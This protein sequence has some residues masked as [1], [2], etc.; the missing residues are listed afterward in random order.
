MTRTLRSPLALAALVVASALTVTAPARLAA[1]SAEA[2]IRK[3]GGGPLIEKPSLRAPADL[4]Y[5][6]VWDVN[7]GP[8]KPDGLVDGFRRPASFLLQADDNGIPRKNVHLAIIVYGTAAR[9]LLNNATYKAETGADNASI[10]LLQALHQS[11]VRVIVCGEALINRRIA[12]DQLLPFV[13]VATTATMARAVL[14]AQG[15]TTF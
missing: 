5:K 14:A 7:V 11:G 13:E 3:H 12:R 8:E 9:S 2:V 1:Q 15:Y 4:V 6:L 10:E